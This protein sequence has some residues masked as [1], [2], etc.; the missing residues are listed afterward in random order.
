M[1]TPLSPTFLSE[2]SAPGQ[3]EF[4]MDLD[5]AA[6]EDFVIGETY[7]VIFPNGT[8]SFRLSG[9]VSFGDA[10]ELREN[11]LRIAGAEDLIVP[12]V[13]DRQPRL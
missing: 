11:P 4:V 2:G 8:E 1:V 12:L 6:N 10:L 13:E 5:T 9:L 3:G 7:D